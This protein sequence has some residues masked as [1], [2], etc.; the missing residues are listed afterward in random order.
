M[1]AKCKSNNM[2]NV[3]L[4]TNMSN[5]KA[6]KLVWDI[7]ELML[8]LQHKHKVSAQQMCTRGRTPDEDIP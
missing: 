1:N 4:F 6:V 8:F 3:K 5:V 7:Q 2:Y